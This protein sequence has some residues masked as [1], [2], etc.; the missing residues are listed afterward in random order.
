MCVD[1]TMSGAKR[2]GGYRK[3]VT[4]AFLSS[5]P[6]PEADECVAKVKG[7][8]GANV[9]EVDLFLGKAETQTVQGKHLALLPKRFKNVI[10]VKRND[11][12]IVKRDMTPEDVFRAATAEA[13]SSVQQYEV[14]HVLSKDQMKHLKSIGKWPEED[15]PHAAGL[16][17][18]DDYCGMGGGEEELGEEEEEEEEVAVA[19]QGEVEQDLLLRAS[20]G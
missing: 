6:E 14:V 13:T 20:L 12:L 2:A 11:Y 10:W 8:R 16:E 15:L 19:P 3:S 1:K 9:F 4:E 7:S 17:E 18:P 5:Y